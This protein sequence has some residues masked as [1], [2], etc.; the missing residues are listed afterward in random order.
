MLSIK[1]VNLRGT[2]NLETI[3]EDCPICQCNIIESCVECSSN[4][5]VDCISVMGECSHVYHLHC[6]ERWIKTKNVCPLDN[7]EWHYKKP[8]LCP[9]IKPN[10]FNKINNNLI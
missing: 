6:I 3:N 8:V 4:N 5:K 9:V 7:K 10:T 1:S 2:W